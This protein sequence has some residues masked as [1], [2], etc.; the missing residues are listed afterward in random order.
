MAAE[1][2]SEE[3]AEGVLLLGEEKVI[4]ERLPAQKEQK[5]ALAWLLSAVAEG[6]AP[7]L[8]VKRKCFQYFE[9]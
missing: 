2:G 7:V 4:V 9:G 3:L 8:C 6:R 1:L 5:E